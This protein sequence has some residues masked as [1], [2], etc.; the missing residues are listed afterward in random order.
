MGGKMIIKRQ[1]KQIK[2]RFLSWGTRWVA[3]SSGLMA[4]RKS[5]HA[6]DSFGN[7][8]HM[9]IKGATRVYE[10]DQDESLAPGKM[11]DQAKTT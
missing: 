11:W 3:M 2:W 5:T 10:T 8:Q 9:G 4:W 1:E 7:Q 6:K